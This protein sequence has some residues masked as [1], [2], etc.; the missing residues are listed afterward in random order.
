M[1]SWAGGGRLTVRLD[2]AAASLPRPISTNRIAAAA[3]VTAAPA[4]APFFPT[5]LRMSSQAIEPER[6]YHAAMVNGKLHLEAEGGNPQ[7]FVSASVGK[8]P[9]RRLRVGLGGANRSLIFG[10]SPENSWPGQ[11]DGP[12]L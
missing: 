7:F 5:P 8:Q 6:L 11:C 9:L 3:V 2:C 10:K 4:I 1:R 12:R